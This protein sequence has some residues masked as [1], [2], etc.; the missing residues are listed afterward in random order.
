[1]VMGAVASVIGILLI[2]YY[3]K[4]ESQRLGALYVILR[5]V[6]GKRYSVTRSEDE[7]QMI[8]AGAT[9]T[10]RVTMIWALSLLL[11]NRHALKKVQDELH[12]QVG[13][14]RL[15]NELDINKLVFTFKLDPRVW[16]DPL[17]FQ[18]ERFLSTHKSVDVK[19][20]HFE[21]LP[22]GGGRRSCPGI[23]F[24]IQMTHLALT[25]FLHAF[26]ITAPSNAQV[27]MTATFGLTNMKTT[28]LELL[29]KPILP[30]QLFFQDEA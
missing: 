29:I 4:R 9:D 21:F 27:N 30:H 23:P 19:G 3:I 5:M 26:E 20:Q 18:P 14:D 25:T 11:N 8:I 7:E 15:V 12:E 13:K 10:T 16:L 17:E 22:F 6:S 2:S 28:P 24:G 1:M